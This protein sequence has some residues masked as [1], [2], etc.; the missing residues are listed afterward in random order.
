MFV[1][2]GTLV[3]KQKNTVGKDDNSIDSLNSDLKVAKLVNTRDYIELNRQ[4]PL[5]RDSVNPLILSIIEPV[6][7]VALNRHEQ[8]TEKLSYM[9]NNL[10]QEIGY[11]NWYASLAILAEEV[12]T[13]GDY[14]QA[15]DILK[16]GMEQVASTM[17]M[18]QSI[19]ETFNSKYIFFNILRDIPKSELLRSSADCILDVTMKET[20]NGQLM[21]IPV[22]LN[23]K[24]ELFLFDTGSNT[25]C[26]VSRRFA[27]ENNIHILA[28]SIQSFN[29]ADKIV[30]IGVADNIRI[31]NISFSNVIFTIS[32]DEGQPAIFGRQ[33][34]DMIGEIQIYPGKKKIIFPL[35]E[36]LMPTDGINLI[37]SFGEPVTEGY[38]EG[39]RLLLKL[40]TGKE[41]SMLSPLF[42]E[43]NEEWVN[44][45]GKEQYENIY[46]Y[47]NVEGSA[48]YILPSARLTIDNTPINLEQIPVYTYKTMNERLFGRLCVDFI[49]GFE[50][51]I[52]DFRRMFIR[53]ENE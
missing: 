21:Y 40:D 45:N 9:L 46:G 23:G 22:M 2:V 48:I 8:A 44:S 11:R 32:D 49:T 27:E 16:T 12:A 15:A 25:Q 51:V 19:H 10:L 50:N 5:L 14:G 39:N 20:G 4:L 28:N 7:C 26:H 33:L 52:V 35:N 3:E 41:K 13:L 31:G 36:T 42:Y 38:L 6:Y 37:N 30:S 18:S 1:E 29:D 53:T 47:D 24:Q 17:P 34:M 43:E